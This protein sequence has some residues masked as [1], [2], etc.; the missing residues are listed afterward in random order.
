MLLKGLPILT[1]G[2]SPNFARRGGIINF[3]LVD[4]K[5]RFEINVEAAKQAN[6]NISSR[7]LS[8]AKI[9]PPDGEK[10]P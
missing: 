6:I 8:L 1:I 4:D 5:V 10:L 7:L 9:I 2:D 3:I